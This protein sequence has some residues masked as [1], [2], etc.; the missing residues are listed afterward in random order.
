MYI[1][2]I[3][4]RNFRCFEH[5]DIKLADGL[6]TIIGEN[7]TGKSNLLYAMRIVLDSALSSSYR[8]LVEHDIN[9]KINPANAC[10][11]IVSVEFSG[12]GDNDNELGLVGCWEVD[13][14]CARLNYRFRPRAEMREQIEAGTHDGTGLTLNDYHWE[15]TGGG[16]KDPAKVK[17][18]ETLGSS[19][20]LGHLQQF[21]VLQLPALRNVTQDM[22]HSR[23]SPLTKLFSASEIPES[24][25]EELVAILKGANESIAGSP[26]I[27]AAGQTIKD[28]FQNASGK[29][30]EMDVKLGMADPTFISIA[31][32]LNILL[33]NDHLKDFDLTRNGLGLNNILYISMLLAYFQKRVQDPRTSGQVLLVEEPEAHLHPQLQRILYK[34]LTEKPIQ[35]IVTTHS[36]HM[37]SQASLDSVVVLTKGKNAKITSLVPSSTLGLM[38]RDKDDLERYLDATRS[39]L[40]FAKKVILVEGPSELYLIPKLVEH[41]LGVDLDRMGITVIS[42]NGCHFKSY[43]KLFGKSGLQ[44]KCA[45]ITDGDREIPETPEIEDELLELD[46]FT[47]EENEF[48]KVFRCETTFERVLVHHDTLG[49]I[50]HTAEEFGA[51][52]TVAL[53]KEQESILAEKSSTKAQKDAAVLDARRLTLA[54]SK[55]IGKARFAQ[56][57]SKHANHIRHVPRYISNAIAWIVK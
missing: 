35:T 37:S 20:R 32:G 56:T 29:A 48:L 7:N 15:I 50:I 43:S 30:Y 24:E 25:K 42:I 44:K 38:V 33:S 1:S 10:Q 55:R 12:Y 13:T 27:G 8:Q 34:E 26:T 51:T 18:M 6:T 54:L 53:L 23:V 31:R 46:D 3:V 36:T 57:A 49:M 14:D 45:I 22:R 11:V 4:I 21:Q 40:L 47:I 5:L 19:I 39:S 28:A 9:S 52:R 2:R 17:W 41:G 16:E